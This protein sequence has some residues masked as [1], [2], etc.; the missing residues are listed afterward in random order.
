MTPLEPENE[1]GVSEAA[2]WV[3]TAGRLATFF[4]FLVRNA[5]F[6]TGSTG[7]TGCNGRRSMQFAAVGDYRRRVVKPVDQTEISW[8]V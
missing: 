3:A 1:R 2:F 6:G 8:D 7:E 5:M 4:Q